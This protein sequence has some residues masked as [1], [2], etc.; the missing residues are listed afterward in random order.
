[1]RA[2]GRWLVA[3]AIVLVVLFPRSAHAAPS[4]ALAE[5]PIALEP[6]VDA[7]VGKVHAKN[8]GDAPLTLAR[9][10]VRDADVDPALARVRTGF[11]NDA[12]HV[13]LAPGETTDI[14]LYW[15]PAKNDATRTLRGYVVVVSTDPEAHERAVG[16]RVARSRSA[17]GALLDHL[18]FLL[19]GIPALG[20][21]VV[22][23]A[24][25]RGRSVALAFAA[26][27]AAI[28]WGVWRGIN[29]NM[30]HDSL[31]LVDRVVV[32]RSL[33]I[34]LFLGVDTLSLP[35]VVS[36]ACL[37]P[38]GVV[39]TPASVPNARA[40]TLAL[41][42]AVLVAL[43]SADGALTL[44]ALSVSVVL[45]L[46]LARAS[47]APAGALLR[48]AGV[49]TVGL[50]AFAIAIGA[51]R[52]CAG[53]GLLVSGARVS[54]WSCTE[55]ARASYLGKG[56]LFGGPLVASAWVLCF[57]ASAAFSGIF[58]LHFGVSALLDE[59]RPHVAFAVAAF[60]L[61]L[62]PQLLLRWAIPLFP[63]GARWAA[64]VVVPLAAFAIALSATTAFASARSSAR[65]P[66]LGRAITVAAT[67]AFAATM[68]LT[69]QGFAA[70]ALYGALSGAATLIFLLLRN[71]GRG[72]TG[73]L[74][75]SGAGS[76]SVLG[77]VAIAARSPASALVVAL[78][79]M[80]LVAAMG[81]QQASLARRRVVPWLAASLL[82]LVLG[83]A[84][85]DGVAPGAR[86]LTDRVVRVGGDLLGA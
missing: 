65:T 24:R 38:V 67:T 82:L 32:S 76:A 59:E 12:T 57:V 43:L 61:R 55:L 62:G 35:A 7:W 58:P 1:M 26:L 70:A 22:F 8:V 20:A 44:L 45:L 13:V 16:F 56:A 15:A 23:V 40:L 84:A 69:T 17:L 49:S 28:G 81:R 21:L 2:L 71:A 18:L 5:G 34:E 77:I 52:A 46:L 64:P 9:A 72:F 10:S 85:V 25:D 31:Q 27:T 50:V 83:A 68:T 51:A 29:P 42:A 3:F 74:V 39:L 48:F 79:L 66:Y 53:T 37:L 6:A 75:V 63:E 73:A 36:V 41:A 33:G 86:A 47:G 60:F 54:V 78:A 30:V 4:L 19:V 14:E 11:A 80:G